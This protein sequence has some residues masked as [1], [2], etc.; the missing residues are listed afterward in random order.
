MIRRTIPWLVV[1]GIMIAAL[2]LRSPIVA[3]TPVLPQIITDLGISATAAG[4]L[5]TA[6]ILMFAAI[7]PVAALIIRRAGP[8]LAMLAML[9]G[10]LLGVLVRA[11]PGYTA[12]LAGMCI[13]G[14]AI[15]IG[16]VVIPVIVRR[17]VPPE[18]VATVNA[19]YIALMNVGS[20]ITAI[21]TAP[22]AELM[23]WRL[24]LLSWAIMTVAGILLWGAHMVRRR[25]GQAS[26]GSPRDRR[27]PEADP[28]VGERAQALTGPTPVVVEASIGTVLRRPIVWLLVITFT[29]QSA[30][31]YGLTTWLPTL[32]VDT[33]GVTP[34]E[35]GAMSSVFQGVAI[36]GALAA[37]LLLRTAGPV[38]T[39]LVMGG[40]FIAMVLGILLAPAWF[41]LW[42]AL[43]A[44][45]HS[46]GFVLIFT[47]MVHTS[48]SASEAA[49]MS[50]TVQ[51]I[52]YV[53]AA[54]GAPTMGAVYDAT[55]SWAP[56]LLVLLTALLVYAVSILSVGARIR[57]VRG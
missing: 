48:S 1:A 12:L 27:E 40:C 47:A 41:L 17:D 5:T 32:L 4:L 30:A 33:T 52:G 39:A 34:A 9:G 56:P 8:E 22:M 51:G 54:L 44:I 2:S 35:A 13:I 50:A 23:G 11:I 43:G 38:L 14:V 36:V 21:G 20:L 26:V 24:A 18:R 15:A 25:A 57:G 7:T 28:R 31:Y 53:G 55:G 3:V 10:V 37:P 49:T 45:A 6:P 16:N 29:T 42:A 46:G 19:M